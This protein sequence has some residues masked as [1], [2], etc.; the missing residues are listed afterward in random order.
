MNRG[1]MKKVFQFA[2]LSEALSSFL[3]GFNDSLIVEY[4]GALPIPPLN[5]FTRLLLVRDGALNDR[6]NTE[7]L[8]FFYMFISIF[9][10]EYKRGRIE[11]PSCLQHAPTLQVLQFNSRIGIHFK[12][13]QYTIPL[14]VE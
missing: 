5:I 7:K 12:A 2:I 1:H 14:E 9:A 11:S 10:T 6:W 3:V 4:I 13:F 8:Q